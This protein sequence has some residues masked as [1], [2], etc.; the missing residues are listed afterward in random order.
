[1]DKTRREF[2]RTL[3]TTTQ[4]GAY[5]VRA[6]PQGK[7]ESNRTLETVTENIPE[8]TSDTT[9]QIQGARKT[10][11]ENAKKTVPR[12][13]T[14][15]PRR[16]RRVPCGSRSRGPGQ[17]PSFYLPSNG[18]QFQAD[19][20]IHVADAPHPWPQHFPSPRWITSSP[21][22]PHS[23]AKMSA[24]SLRFTQLPVP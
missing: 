18:R 8:L 12:P 17:G 14:V 24:R 5:N 23:N 15:Q 10:P 20:S 22:H 11:R 4:G 16:T 2:H 19:I 13:V 7:R 1:M 9:P 6:I 3:G 21:P